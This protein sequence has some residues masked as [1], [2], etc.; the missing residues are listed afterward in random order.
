L[1]CHN[2]T[3]LRVGSININTFPKHLEQIRIQFQ[4]SWFLYSYKGTFNNFHAKSYVKLIFI[5][6][7]KII[8]SY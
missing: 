3:T 8:F 4:F 1:Q 5:W 7:N 2:F 6:N